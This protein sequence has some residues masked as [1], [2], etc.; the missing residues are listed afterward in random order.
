M[1]GGLAAALPRRIWRCAAV[2]VSDSNWE[3]EELNHDVMAFCG[4]CRKTNYG[5]LTVRPASIDEKSLQTE[6][7]QGG[8]SGSDKADYRG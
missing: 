8:F 5:I 7:P 6:P 1:G 3:R 2:C 4:N